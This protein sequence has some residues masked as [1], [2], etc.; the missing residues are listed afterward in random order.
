MI[1]YKDSSENQRYRAVELVTDLGGA[2][3]YSAPNNY[4]TKFVTKVIRDHNGGPFWLQFNY[5][6]VFSNQP[7]LQAI[8][9]NDV[10]WFMRRFGQLSYRQVYDSFLSSGFPDLI[11]QILTG[12]LMGRRNQIME[13]LGLFGEKTGGQVFK[14]EREFTGEIAGYEKFFKNGDLYDPGQSLKLAEGEEP[15]PIY[16]TESKHFDVT[17]PLESRKFKELGI[18]S[19]NQFMDIISG[20]DAENKDFKNFRLELDSAPLRKP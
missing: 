17:S 9:F 5:P 16:W 10:K 4:V 7:M 12:K 18:F 11:A 2:F 15:F 19:L 13:A 14:R 20:K 1:P 3:S 8:T 6:R